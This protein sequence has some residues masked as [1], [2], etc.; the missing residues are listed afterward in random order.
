MPQILG[1]VVS[2]ARSP[3]GEIRELHLNQPAVVVNRGMNILP[4]KLVCDGFQVGEMSRLI[5]ARI[6]TVFLLT[7]YHNFPFRYIDSLT[8]GLFDSIRGTFEVD[9]PSEARN[10]VRRLRRAEEANEDERRERERRELA[11]VRL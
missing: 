10:V 5:T 2:W 7:L 3:D 8:R 1:Y 11:G 9:S 4:T 6:G